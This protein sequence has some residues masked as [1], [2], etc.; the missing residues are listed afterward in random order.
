MPLSM[1]EITYHTYS[2]CVARWWK[3]LFPKEAKEQPQQFYLK[4]GVLKIAKKLPN[5]WATFKTKFASN[6]FQK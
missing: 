5:I 2:L 6:T 1:C 4:C 3:P